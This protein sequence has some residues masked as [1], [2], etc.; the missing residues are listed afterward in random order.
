MVMHLDEDDVVEVVQ[1]LRLLD[2]LQG[3]HT[4]RPMGCWFGVAWCGVGWV[5]ALYGVVWAI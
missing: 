3:L 2:Q 4:W 1:Q 5:V